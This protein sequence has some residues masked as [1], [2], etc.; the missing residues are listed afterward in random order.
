MLKFVKGNYHRK[1]PKYGESM[2]SKREIEVLKLICKG[3]T[4]A[5]I[6]NQLFISVKTVEGH[7]KNLLEKT[8]MSNSVSLAVYA[9]KNEIVTE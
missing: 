4:T 2:L 7:R 8:G 1:V 6:S 3:L 9:I 5:E